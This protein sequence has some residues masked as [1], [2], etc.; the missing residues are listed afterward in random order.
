MVQN[1]YLS[2]ILVQVQQSPK[3][4]PGTDDSPYQMLW[5]VQ[6]GFLVIFSTLYDLSYKLQMVNFYP[7]THQILVKTKNQILLFLANTCKQPEKI[8]TKKKC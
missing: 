2:G 4:L 1:S 5:T 6:H 8:S 7:L 3:Q